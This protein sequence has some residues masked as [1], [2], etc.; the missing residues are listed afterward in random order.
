MGSQP[1]SGGE[2]SK[3]MKIVIIILLLIVLVP[4]SVVALPLSKVEITLRNLET[5]DGVNVMVSVSGADDGYF[6]LF[7]EP[8]GD[9]T[10]SCYVHAG[11]H[12]IRVQ[13]YYPGDQ[14]Y[15]Y[16]SIYESVTSWPFGSESLSISLSK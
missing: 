2:V 7:I 10:V 9:E 11:S 13:Y 3:R 15:Y 5:E 14:Y 4:A 6:D 8:L 16:R 1:G 12:G